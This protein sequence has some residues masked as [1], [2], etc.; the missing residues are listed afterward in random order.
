DSLHRG[1]LRLAQVLYGVG[2]SVGQVLLLLVINPGLLRLWYGLLIVGMSAL[3]AIVFLIVAQ[4]KLAETPR[5]D[6]P[7]IQ[8]DLTLGDLSAAGRYV[9]VILWLLADAFL[10][11]VNFNLFNVITIAAR[12]TPPNGVDVEEMLWQALVNGALNTLMYLV[13]F[14]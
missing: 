14:L 8:L 4:S 9:T 11:R 6:V 3:L 13:I 5:P 7:V 10:I 2:A 1:M 12:T